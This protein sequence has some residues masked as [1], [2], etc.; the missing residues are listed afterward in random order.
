M[1][2][3][4]PT[5]KTDPSINVKN[6]VEESVTRLD[7]LRKA[8]IRR[9]DEKIN[10]NDI[11]YQIQF[12]DS[13]EAVTAALTAT[14]EAINKADQ[15]NEKRFDAVNEFRSTLSDQQTKLMTRT[16]YESAHGAITE[17]IDGVTDR[18]N[19]TEGASGVYVTHNDL[20][21]ALDK[22]QQNIEITLRPVVTF[23]N[24]QTGKTEGVSSSWAIIATI[25]GISI[26][27]VTLII[28]FVN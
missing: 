27:A 1:N 19:R 11:K 21:I 22:L 10:L 24:N 7:D 16:E 14:K 3:D 18:I 23:M 17:K 5:V 6:I 12:A 15:A 4:N 26:A 25:I 13:K 8:E 9:V 2:N 28:K 20:T